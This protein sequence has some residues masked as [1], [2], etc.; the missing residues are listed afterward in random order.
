MTLFSAHSLVRKYGF[1]AK[2]NAFLQL[3]C[4]FGP[5]LFSSLAVNCELC[6]L[7][8]AALGLSIF[9][10]ASKLRERN[11][12]VNLVYANYFAHIFA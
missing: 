9:K 1:P 5:Q 12:L 8:T 7:N 4:F 11:H 2:R 10:V 6:S 3:H